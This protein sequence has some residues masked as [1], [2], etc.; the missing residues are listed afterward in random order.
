M[1][2]KIKTRYSQNSFEIPK[3]LFPGK[4]EAPYIKQN[5]AK[6]LRNQC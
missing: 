4:Q 2:E 6:N 5:V 3:L 1:K